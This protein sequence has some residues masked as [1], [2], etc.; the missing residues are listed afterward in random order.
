[1]KLTASALFD[2][3]NLNGQ[4]PAKP[5]FAPSGRQ[6][7]YLAVATD[8]RD[9]LDLY[10]YDADARSTACLVDARE[11]DRQASP[12]TDEEKAQQERR[13]TFTRGISDYAWRADGEALLLVC[14]G[15]V[16][17]L[18]IAP[19]S[20]RRI[21][22]PGTR[23]TDARFSRT[24]RYIGYV[25]A[26]DL[27]V[28]DLVNDRERRLTD[29][30]STVVTNGLA[31][32]IAQ[33]EMHRFDG[34]WFSADDR[35]LAYSR[36]DVSGVAETQRYEI[37]ADQF[38]V[39]AQRYP[40]AGG[41][42]ADVALMLLDLDAGARRAVRYQDCADDYL[43]RVT[44]SATQLVTQVQARDQRTLRV[45]SFPLDTL[46]PRVLLLEQSTTWIN[47]HDNLSFLP[48]SDDFVWTS[49]RDGDM[50]LY[51]YR[52]AADPV[53]L[54]WGLG[55]VNSV[56][57]T[58]A[59]GVCF[60]G[61]FEHP[62]EQHGYRI[63]YARPGVLERLTE[64]PGWHELTVARDGRSYVSRTSSLDTPPTLL[65][66]RAGDST[67]TNVGGNVLA[68]GHP[69]WPY[70]STHCRQE[71]G[72]LG[73][74]DDA[75]WYRLTYPSGF[76]ASVR[77]PVIVHVY[78]GPGIQRVRNEWAPLALQLFAQQ[79]YVVFELD[80]RGSGNRSKR[81]EAPIHR[82]L[83][84]VEVDDQLR[85]VEYLA[86]QNWIDA[87]RIGVYGHSYGG[88]M[89]L[90]CLCRAPDVF[91][92]GVSIAPV[93]D[94][95]LYDTHYTERY[96][97]TPANNA[98]GYAESAATTLLEHLRGALL[99]IHG[100]AD[101]NVLFTHSTKL[102]KTLQDLRKPFEMMTYPGAKHALQ[103]P[104]VAVH[105]YQTALA[106]FARTLLA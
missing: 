31:E 63:A 13:R 84:A 100:M 79:G 94:W 34:Y 75:L 27:Y 66:Q 46:E 52:A 7:T 24:G 40:F 86:R 32:F 69:Y 9:R 30:A 106:F 50:H 11:L 95:S 38:N 74:G 12:I 1:V 14:D 82:R 72:H 48:D 58:D 8:D 49:Q 103:Q 93:A 96:L 62:V 25:R 44:F 17:L 65:L 47:L 28:Y 37:E 21:T 70:H 29:D 102:F 97:D 53:Q 85:G 16:F 91:K 41:T 92:A 4:T 54:T 99:I 35:Y 20:L 39:F 60:A 51:L 98:D 43:A 3:A 105:R 10:L 77:Y 45:K 104:D 83:G 89:T 59:D 26:G 81:F 22:P 55:R 6:I 87:A 33:E 78:G 56:L 76:D 57:H 36:V 90:M 80:N 88:F 61:W 15:S 2:G 71:I 64:A 23:Q 42:N 68:E 18:Q 5:G 67:A 101:D 19:R 73:D